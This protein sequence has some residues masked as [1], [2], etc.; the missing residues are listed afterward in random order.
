MMELWIAECELRIEKPETRNPQSGI[1][2]SMD[3]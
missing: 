2:N 1:R 3:G